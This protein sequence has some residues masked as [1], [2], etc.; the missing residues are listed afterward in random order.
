M[1][2]FKMIF[3][4]LLSTLVYP[5][6]RNVLSLLLMEIQSSQSFKE[7]KT[8]KQYHILRKFVFFF[9]NSSL[10]RT[11]QKASSP[12]SEILLMNEEP[13]EF[14][15]SLQ[16]VWM[17][18][19]QIILKSYP[20]QMSTLAY[21]ITNHERCPVSTMTSATSVSDCPEMT[22]TILALHAEIWN[23]LLSRL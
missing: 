18:W 7:K 1:T 10:R 11:K 20:T 2:H 5:N 12:S 17:T 22:D 3:R 23:K 19:K 4:F 8:K 15:F 13:S 16:N 9:F 6:L 14:S 21:G